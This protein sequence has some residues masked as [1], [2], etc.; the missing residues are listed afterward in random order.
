MS[1]VIRTVG[2]DRF[3]PT[4]SIIVRRVDA[5]RHTFVLPFLLEHFPKRFLLSLTSIFRENVDGQPVLRG[6]FLNFKAVS[7]VHVTNGPVGNRSSIVQTRRSGRRNRTRGASGGAARPS[8][9]SCWRTAWRGETRW[10]MK[11]RRMMRPRWARTLRR[12]T[13][14]GLKTTTRHSTDELF[15]C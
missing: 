2:I 8:R 11:R 6:I 10:K 3:V 12:G 14:K 9:R 13:E 1:V 7:T 5:L 15:R 4:A